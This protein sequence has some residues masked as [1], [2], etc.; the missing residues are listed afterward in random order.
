MR[1][2]NRW[3]C[4]SRRRRPMRCFMI[5]PGCIDRGNYILGVNTSLANRIPNGVLSSVDVRFAATYGNP[6]LRTAT[7]LGFPN[8]VNTAKPASTPAPPPY[9][10][11]RSSVIIPSGTSSH[12]ITSP[13]LA[14]PQCA[15]SPITTSTVSTDS[16]QPQVATS[17]A[18][19]QSPSAHYILA[20]SNRA[21]GNATV[22]KKG[23]NSRGGSVV[24]KLGS[25]DGA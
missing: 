16:T 17:T 14:S 21:V 4:A 18:T 23:Y 11:V 22:T 20:P 3:A 13:S 9:S 7:T 2:D 15:T 12:S 6:H 25:D 24:A 19:P 10:S 5:S 1:S 8:T